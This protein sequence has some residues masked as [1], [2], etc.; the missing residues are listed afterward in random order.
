MM[1][2]KLAATKSPQRNNPESLRGAVQFGPALKESLKDRTRAS[3]SGT[4]Q[5]SDGKLH[6]L[7]SLLQSPPTVGKG[8]P[9]EDSGDDPSSPSKIVKY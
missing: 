6:P 9:F 8:G 7:P 5:P 3:A 2:R 1:G 4:N